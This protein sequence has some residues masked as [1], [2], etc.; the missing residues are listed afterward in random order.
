[1]PGAMDAVASH[2]RCGERCASSGTPKS[3]QKVRDSRRFETVEV[4]KSPPNEKESR[5]YW[6]FAPSVSACCR[7]R[8]S[9]RTPSQRTQPSTDRHERKPSIRGRR[10]RRRPV[11]SPHRP[12][13]RDR[14]PRQRAPRS[15]R[16]TQAR[17]AAPRQP[18]RGAHNE[19]A[20]SSGP[21]LGSARHRSSHGCLCRAEHEPGLRSAS[22]DRSAAVA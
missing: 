22:V 8:Q 10:P 16:G 13:C 18:S 20:F 3:S 21:I 12:A 14:P 7:G 6:G 4:R 9:C 15:A 2:S 17:P 19:S 11:C 1:M 5:T